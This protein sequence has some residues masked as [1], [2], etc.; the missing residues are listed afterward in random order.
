MQLRH[1]AHIPNRGPLANTVVVTQEYGPEFDSTNTF[2]QDI[3]WKNQKAKFGR[4]TSHVNEK[5]SNVYH[6]QQLSENSGVTTP[7]QQQHI[8]H[9]KKNLIGKDNTYTPNLI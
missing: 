4:T 8:I 6:I 2:S 7:S 3:A 9:S 5:L 1:A